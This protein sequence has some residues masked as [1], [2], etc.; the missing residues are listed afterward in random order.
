MVVGPSGVGKRTLIQALIEKYG[1]LFERKKSY[2]TRKPRVD[3]KNPELFHFV[4]EE[5]F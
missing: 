3:E 2:T 5:T 4:S 1:M